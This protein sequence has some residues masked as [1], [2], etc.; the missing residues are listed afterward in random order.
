MKKFAKKFA[1]IAFSLS[2]LALAAALAS[3]NAQTAQSTQGTAGS[4]A[5]STEAHTHSFGG[6]WARDEAAHWQLCSCGEK[7]AAEAH[8][9]NN[10]KKCTVCGIEKA[11]E[12]LAYKYENG[13]F[14]V[15]GIGT[16]TDTKI[17]IPATYEGSPVT[18]VAGSAFANNESITSVTFGDNVKTIG[19]GAFFACTALKSITVPESTELINT[20]AF[21]FCSSLGTIS[22]PRGGCEIRFGA[23]SETAYA[24]NDKNRKDGVLYIGEYLISCR[25]QG[26]PQKITVKEGTKY[27]AQ[28]AF[29]NADVKE[30]ILPD[31]VVSI[32]SF[33]FSKSSVQKIVLPKNLERIEEG[34]FSYSALNEITIPLS[35][36]YI[37]KDAFTAAGNRETA[38]TYQGQIL[39]WKAI[40]L[41]ENA[42][43]Y[44]ATITC[45]DGKIVLPETA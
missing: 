42:L 21:Y 14:T 25:E 24:N 30:V 15:T 45:T 18:A 26:C 16:C 12:G 2:A 44:F 1:K 20:N 22:L 38:V 5:G 40:T 36:K 43:P 13:E 4:T 37:G 17:V 41:G 11:S 33:A 3:C 27:I 31:S 28:S 9:Y 29:L 19:D 8:K 23:F 6:A 32:G 10:S 35:V 34:T 39:Q 7:S